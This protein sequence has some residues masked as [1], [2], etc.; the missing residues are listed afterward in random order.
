MVSRTCHMGILKPYDSFDDWPIV[1]RYAKLLA[2]YVLIAVA[3]PLLVTGGFHV[4]G[5]MDTMDALKSYKTKEEKLEILKDPHIGAFAVIMLAAAGLIYTAAMAGMDRS[6]VA[7]FAG[8]FFLARALSGTAV[9]VFPPAKK[10]GM[11]RTFSDTSGRGKSK[12]VLIAL[13]VEAA[14]GAAFMIIMDPLAGLLMVLAALAVFL[15][16]RYKSLKEFG[17][18]TGDTAGFFVTVSEIAMA[19]AAWIA[20]LII[21]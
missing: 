19:V 16:Y 7:S 11:L 14:A 8:S 18:I 10:D 20:S 6:L 17:G 9:M 13:L 2:V 12:T 21:A 1:K 15:Y 4:D 5:Y 3:I